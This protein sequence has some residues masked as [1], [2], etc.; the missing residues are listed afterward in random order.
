[1]VG[2]NV[3]IDRVAEAEAALGE[4]CLVLLDGERW[5]DDRGLMTLTRGNKVRR[6][7]TPFIEKLL[8]VHGCVLY[9]LLVEDGKTAR[10]QDGKTARRQD[11]KTARRVVG[12]EGG[13]EL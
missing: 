7:A 6:A 5:I 13:R 2:V 11:G 1:M 12:P 9:G 10:R 8:E 4:E 3:R